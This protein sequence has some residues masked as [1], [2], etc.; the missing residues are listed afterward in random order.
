[1]FNFLSPNYWESGMNAVIGVFCFPHVLVPRTISM[2]IVRVHISRILTLVV[3][4]Y[5]RRHASASC[6]VASVRRAKIAPTFSYLL[7]EETFRSW[8]RENYLEILLSA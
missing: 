4:V 2:S 8:C 5:T 3:R 6:D 7:V 1:M